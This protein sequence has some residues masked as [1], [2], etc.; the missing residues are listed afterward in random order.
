MKG[1]TSLLLP[2]ACMRPLA[3][4]DKR[5]PRLLNSVESDGFVG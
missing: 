5:E 1:G 4:S 3:R 2:D